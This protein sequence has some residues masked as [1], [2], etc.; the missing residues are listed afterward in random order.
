MATAAAVEARDGL[1]S[2]DLLLVGLTFA[3]G[4]VDAIAFLGLGKVF[5]AFM[6]GNLVFLGLGLAGGD[7]P[8]LRR[9]A[10]TLAGFGL[11]VFVAARIVKPANGSD[12]W[13]RRVSV[14]L[15]LAVLAEALFALGWLLT[16]G[17]PSTPAG[18]LLVALTALAFG[19]QSRAVLSLDVNGVFTT[20]ATGTVIALAGDV[21]GWSR[22]PAERRRLAG[23]L[24]GLVLGAAAGAFLLFHARAYAPILPL[25]ATLAVV[26]GGPILLGARA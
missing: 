17:R 25:G 24:V 1:E 23:V 5:S 19:L 13:S 8:D 14:A 18:D 16:S 2:R 20:A 12:L 7:G 11:G 15:G 6:T 4:A 3:S 26:A 21:A 10:A 9:V 22:S